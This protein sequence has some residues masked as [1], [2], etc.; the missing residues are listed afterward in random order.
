MSFDTTAGT[1]G[2]RQP[3]GFALRAV[4]KLMA[5][6]I[7]RKGGGRVAARRTPRRGGWAWMDRDLRPFLGQLPLFP[8][9]SPLA[10]PAGYLGRMASRPA[11]PQLGLFD[12]PV[13]VFSLDELAET[14]SRIHSLRR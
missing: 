4:N 7:R 9:K 3:S 13:R 10:P 8:A 2:A 5:S 11:R 6:R 14:V 12:N 1:R